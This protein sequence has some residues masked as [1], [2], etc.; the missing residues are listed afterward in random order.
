MGSGLGFW[1]LLEASFRDG[2]RGE[3]DL[4][5]KS[6]GPIPVIW[7]ETGSGA[8]GL[9]WGP[10]PSFCLLFSG[11]CPGWPCQTYM[12]GCWVLVIA[13][14]PG[15]LV[16]PCFAHWLG[17][18]LILRKALVWGGLSFHLTGRETEAERGSASCRGH[19]AEGCLSQGLGQG[20]VD[21]E[22]PGCL[23]SPLWLMS[24]LGPVGLRN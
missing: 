24:L 10:A 5:E 17:P 16:V 23:G 8:L 14:G 13:V 1:V 12:T 6:K 11:C 7:V 19:T 20:S 21:P 4:G 15:Y 9:H 18:H 22:T 3:L 2:G